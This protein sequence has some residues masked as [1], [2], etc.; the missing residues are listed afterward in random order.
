MDYERFSFLKFPAPKLGGISAPLNWLNSLPRKDLRKRVE[1]FGIV[2]ELPTFESHIEKTGIILS[3]RI[4][5]MEEMNVA[6]LGYFNQSRL[7]RGQDGD[8]TM[9]EIR[10]KTDVILI[11][12]LLNKLGYHATAIEE[13]LGAGTFGGGRNGC[14]VSDMP[15]S[16]SLRLQSEWHSDVIPVVSGER[17][18]REDAA[19]AKRRRIEKANADLIKR[20][21]PIVEQV[22]GDDF[23]SR[24]TSYPQ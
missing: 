12:Y 5:I 9:F 13:A 6:N 21:T 15:W 7:H 8:L 22:T 24:L 10:S 4:F 18:K 19:E 1:L 20:N 3:R 23:T 16:E 11:N 14:L 17:K 2:S